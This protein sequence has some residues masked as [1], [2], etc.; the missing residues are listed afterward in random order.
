MLNDFYRR[1]A[2]S[3]GD[4]DGTNGVSINSQYIAPS[5]STSTPARNVVVNDPPEAA[6]TVSQHASIGLIEG[7]LPEL[8][9]KLEKSRKRT[10]E[11]ANDAAYDPALSSPTKRAKVSSYQDERKFPTKVLKVDSIDQDQT[12][13]F[14][15]NR[16]SIIS[17]NLGILLDRISTGAAHIENRDEN[18]LPQMLQSNTS[19]HSSNMTSWSSFFADKHLAS[20]NWPSSLQNDDMSFETGSVIVLDLLDATDNE[21]RLGCDVYDNCQQSCEEDTAQKLQEKHVSTVSSTISAR[22]YPGRFSML[23]AEQLSSSS[24]GPT[25]HTFGITYHPNG[26]IINK[27]FTKDRF[28]QVTSLNEA[29]VMQD[30]LL[31]AAI[32]HAE[33]TAARL[34]PLKQMRSLRESVLRRE[35]HRECALARLE[36]VSVGYFRYFAG[37]MT[38]EEYLAARMCVCWSDCF[39]NKLCTRSGDLLCPCSENIELCD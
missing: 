15:E 18:S 5:F 17:L 29:D 1:S 34:E 27:A 19:S 6:K 22:G 26:R 35:I 23:H 9:L 7:I 3:I 16:S 28:Y 20:G 33:V 14:I 39:C 25:Q 38:V 21:E 36:G 31:S 24:D 8:S 4:I 13:T 11:A 32:R 37:H 10:R 12:E 30:T 2:I